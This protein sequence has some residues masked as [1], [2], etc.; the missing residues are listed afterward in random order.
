MCVRVSSLILL[1]TNRGLGSPDLCRIARNMESSL[2]ERPARL[3]V[4][5]HA[6]DASLV[7]VECCSRDAVDKLLEGRLT[8]EKFTEGPEP[9]RTVV[10]HEGDALELSLRGNIEVEADADDQQPSWTRR[11]VYNS[12]LSSVS[13]EVSVREINKFA[14]NGFDAFHGYIRLRLVD[15]SYQPPPKLAAVLDQTVSNS[16]KSTAALGSK[17]L[18]D[19]TDKNL[20]CEVMISLPKV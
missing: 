11:F 4:R 17:A 12:K 16:K 10:L 9:S 5:Q 7:F 18:A 1:R 8:D 2:N 6:H 3:V 19:V 13:A 14:Q 15:Q 20:L